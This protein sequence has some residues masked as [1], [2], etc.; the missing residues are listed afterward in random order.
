M[1][2]NFDIIRFSKFMNDLENDNVYTYKK[3]EVLEQNYLNYKEM[4]EENFG[5]ELGDMVG[6]AVTGDTM[7]KLGYGLKGMTKAALDK[8]DDVILNNNASRRRFKKATKELFQTY[9][10]DLS[11]LIENYFYSFDIYETNFWNDTCELLEMSPEEK[12]RFLTRNKHLISEL[13][14]ESLEFKKAMR[15]NIKEV[16]PK[17]SIGEYFTKHRN[18]RNRTDDI[19]NLLSAYKKWVKETS[20]KRYFPLIKD[21]SGY[22][23]LKYMSDKQKNESSRAAGIYKLIEEI[24]EDNDESNI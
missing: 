7:K 8:F 6:K 11:G 5:A 15:N 18:S 2:E 3:K 4:L 9:K 22:M 1:S 12:K 14:K 16:E 21:F 17:L 13:R 10:D 23:I 19:N 24:E 20:N